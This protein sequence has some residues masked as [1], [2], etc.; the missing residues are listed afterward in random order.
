MGFLLRV[1]IFFCTIVLGEDDSHVP[2]E[3]GHY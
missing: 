3:P 2:Q 1:A